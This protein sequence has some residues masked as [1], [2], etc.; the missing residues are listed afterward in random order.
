MCPNHI[1]G[2]SWVPAQGKPVCPAFLQ[3]VLDLESPT[4]D[5]SP[6]LSPVP[7]T[8]Q[9]VSLCASL[10]L[11]PSSH[12]GQSCPAKSVPEPLQEG[13]EAGAPQ[14]PGQGTWWPLTGPPAQPREERLRGHVARAEA[15]ARAVGVQPSTPG[16]CCLPHPK[17][18]H[19]RPSR[20]RKRVREGGATMSCGSHRSHMAT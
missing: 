18:Q 16:P 7:W 9:G 13:L 5:P 12:N 15:P 11:C 1:L 8:C 3:G 17:P 20:G 2:G 19:P 14:A 10:S 4:W 6:S